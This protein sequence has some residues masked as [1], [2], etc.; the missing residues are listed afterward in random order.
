MR[1]AQFSLCCAQASTTRERPRRHVRCRHDA[2]RRL[3]RDGGKRRKKL[4]R[5]ASGT[6]KLQKQSN[7]VV[8]ISCLFSFFCRSH[9]RWVRFRLLCVRVFFSP[10]SHGR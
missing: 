2:A 9:F 3:S 10:S 4:G 7:T 6:L 1:T 5:K 8:A